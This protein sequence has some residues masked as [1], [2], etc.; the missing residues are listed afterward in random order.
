MISLAPCRFPRVRVK[1]RVFTCSSHKGVTYTVHRILTFITRLTSFCLQSFHHRF[2]GW[3]KPSHAALILGTLTDLPK[4]RSQLM[5]ENA[6]LRQQL[7]ILRRQVKRPACTRTDRM[8]VVLLA[9]IVRSWK[10][11]LVI[12]QPETLLRWH[13]QGYKLFWRYK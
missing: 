11:A 6:L 10:Q 2:V 7:I 3:T 1:S 8:L 13:R 5:A 9:K 12:V 4:S